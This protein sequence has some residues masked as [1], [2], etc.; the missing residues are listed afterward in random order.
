TRVGRT[1]GRSGKLQRPANASGSVRS[2]LRR[3]GVSWSSGLCPTPTRN[4]AGR[5]GKTGQSGPLALTVRPGRRARMMTGLPGQSARPAAD[6]AVIA[7]SGAALAPSAV[8]EEDVLPAVRAE[9]V[10]GA[11]NPGQGGARAASPA[12]RPEVVDTE[13]VS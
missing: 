1:R 11:G 2:R 8:P 4:R 5:G 7:R 6:S 10:R 12:G 9:A 3:D 13:A